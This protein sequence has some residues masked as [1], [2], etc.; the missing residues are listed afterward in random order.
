MDS[1]INKQILKSFETYRNA[2]HSTNSDIAFWTHFVN[3]SVSEY[4]TKRIS[5]MPAYASIFCAYNIDPFLNTGSLM[6]GKD[7]KILENTK[8]E[9]SSVIFFNWVLNLS[10][11]K[12]YNSLEIFLLDAIAV[13]Y[14]PDEISSDHKKING[15][16]QEYLRNNSDKV[17]TKNNK[18]IIQFLS[19]ESEAFKSFSNNFVRIDL[20]T[21]WEQFFEFISILR[22][23]IVHNAMILTKDTQ[24]IVKTL[25]KDIFERYFGLS[26]CNVLTPQRGNFNSFIGLINDF[27]LNTIKIASGKSDFSCFDMIHPYDPIQTNTM[28]RTNW[29]GD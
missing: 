1:N 3:N 24:N 18:H 10:I 8:L 12:V 9:E 13:I 20:K 21:T 5:I 26:D 22:N 16:I 28:R 19:R 29:T 11:L 4:E 23:I 7:I 17:N 2:V 27:A 15:K 14:F 25:S 6:G